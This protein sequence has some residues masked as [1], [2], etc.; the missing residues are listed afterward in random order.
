[1]IDTR[2]SEAELFRALVDG[3]SNTEQV[4]GYIKYKNNVL[5]LDINSMHDDKIVAERN[6]RSWM[7]YR[8]ELVV[9]I[10]GQSAFSDDNAALVHQREVALNII[11]LP[12]K[13]GAT[14]EFVAEFEL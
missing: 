9:F 1:M 3:L 8:Y 4:G 5:K 6:E 10:G 12:Q 14:I 7:Y 11:T 2:L 13:L